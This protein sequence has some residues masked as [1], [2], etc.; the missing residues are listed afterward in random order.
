MKT[1]WWVFC[2]KEEWKKNIVGSKYFLSRPIKI[3][4]PQNKEKIEGGS[5]IC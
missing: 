2:W 4:F 1:F 5:V 3:F